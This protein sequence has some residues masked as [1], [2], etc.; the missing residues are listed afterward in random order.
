VLTAGLLAAC[1]PAPPIATARRVDLERFMGNGH[2]VHLADQSRLS[3]RL[4]G[5]GPAQDGNIA[6]DLALHRSGRLDT[7]YAGSGLPGSLGR[8]ARE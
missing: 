8:F 1:A 3:R 2:A 6:K 7:A 5:A 4:L